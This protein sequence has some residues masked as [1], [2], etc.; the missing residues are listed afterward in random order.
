MWCSI[1]NTKYI[2]E[3]IVVIEIMTVDIHTKMYITGFII[4]GLTSLF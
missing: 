3:H 1:L 4:S 2:H